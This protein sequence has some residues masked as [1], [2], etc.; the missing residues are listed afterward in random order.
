MPGAALTPPIRLALSSVPGL[1]SPL[2]RE[3]TSQTAA[4][5]YNVV[6]LEGAYD[7]LPPLRG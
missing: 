1:H 2:R 6:I 4:N 5:T 3:S 7:A